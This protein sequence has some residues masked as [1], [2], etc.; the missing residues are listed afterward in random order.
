M[1]EQKDTSLPI[2]G[3]II[4]PT[5]VYIRLYR[6][7]DERSQ[8]NAESWKEFLDL[9]LAEL[10]SSN[11]PVQGIP[12]SDSKVRFLNMIQRDLEVQ[13]LKAGDT[14]S[15]T[16]Y[17][18]D[19]K[20][21]LAEFQRERKDFE[22]KRLNKPM[23]VS[24]IWH[25]RALQLT[26][27]DINCIQKVVKKWNRLLLSD[28]KVPLQDRSISL[29]A[30][31]DSLK[32]TFRIRCI[33][34]Q[35]LKHGYLSFET[36]VPK[37]NPK[38]PEDGRVRL[39]PSS[40]SFPVDFFDGA[41][42][43]RIFLLWCL[44]RDFVFQSV[45]IFRLRIIGPANWVTQYPHIFSTKTQG[46]YWYAP[47]LRELFQP[48][49][50]ADDARIQHVQ[51]ILDTWHQEDR[52]H[53]RWYRAWLADRAKL[54][55]LVWADLHALVQV[56]LTAR[57]LL[58]RSASPEQ[59]DLFDQFVKLRKDP[60]D[61]SSVRSGADDRVGFA[62]IILEPFPWSEQ[63][64]S[65]PMRGGGDLDVDHFQGHLARHVLHIGLRENN[66]LRALSLLPRTHWKEL[67]EL[68]PDV[69]QTFVQ[70]AIKKLRFWLA[71]QKLAVSSSFAQT[72]FFEFLHRFMPKELHANEDFD[73]RTRDAIWHHVVETSLREKYITLEDDHVRRVF[74]LPDNFDAPVEFN[75]Q[76]WNGLDDDIIN[77]DP[78]LQVRTVR[79]LWKGLVMAPEVEEVLAHIRIKT[80]EFKE[81]E[82]V[83]EKV[84]DKIQFIVNGH[85]WP[86]LKHVARLL[87]HIPV[88]R[89]RIVFDLAPTTKFYQLYR[90]YLE[91]ES[92][93]DNKIHVDSM[94]PDIPAGLDHPTNILQE[95][96][97]D[98]VEQSNG[99]NPLAHVIGFDTRYA[100]DVL[101]LTHPLANS[102]LHGFRYKESI[103]SAD[104]A[105]NPPF[106]VYECVGSVMDP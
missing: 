72:V 104:P 11:P 41:A 59:P 99:T 51:K 33:H 12:K 16:F 58:F 36:K 22:Y 105:Y 100:R 29:D 6:T 49:A 83:T 21:T 19:I 60:P 96:L 44:F 67:I 84:I 77:L 95:M 39:S 93:K 13:Y 87:L 46:K 79:E 47:L 10:E 14:H 91:A 86:A 50:L 76:T 34:P 90:L 48:G 24:C 57:T 102:E 4:L 75:L 78:I 28:N 54:F 63:P 2:L 70:Q 89:Q 38:K 94:W 20:T 45:D 35:T 27:Q 26:C 61:W 73:R 40:S 62:R 69:F 31:Q 92:A 9:L 8:F 97:R 74:L 56:L 18:T 82:T 80:L 53:V 17:P 30:F 88:V 32:R 23:G 37:E 5:S 1:A 106:Y 52:V 98:T 81:S 64:R 101:W 66:V 43:R 68:H 55:P 65:T 42:S 7:L 103:P 85:Q 25:E 71:R 3:S 15:S